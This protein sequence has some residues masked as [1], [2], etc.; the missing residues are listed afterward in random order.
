[1]HVS[2][3][4]SQFLKLGLQVSQKNVLGGPLGVL[5]MLELYLDQAGLELVIS[6]AALLQSW[7]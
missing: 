2:A 1:M 6:I 5:A 4:V 7:D 3:R